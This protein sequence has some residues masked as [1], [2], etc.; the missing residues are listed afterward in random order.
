MKY[1]EKKEGNGK[2]LVRSPYLYAHQIFNRS[3]FVIN[4]YEIFDHK[5]IL[6]LHFIHQLEDYLSILLV[7]NMLY[8]EEGLLPLL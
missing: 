3:N 2:K 4:S 8:K 6:C 7:L 5:V 1:K